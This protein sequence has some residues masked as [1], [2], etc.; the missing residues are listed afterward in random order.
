M[1]LTLHCFG[2]ATPTGEALRHLCP[3]DAFGYSRHP[4]ASS[5]W[6]YPADLNDPSSFHSASI[7]ATP[8]IWISFAP[9]WLFASFLDHL[10][11]HHPERLQGLR[12]VVAC[13]SSSVITKRFAANLSDRQLVAKLYSSER[14]LLTTCKRLSVPCRILSP[15]LIYGKVGSFSD[16]NLS[17][18]LSFMRRTPL[19]L[20][21]SHSGLRQPI[22]ATQLAAVALHLAKQLVDSSFDHKLPERIVIGGDTSLTYADMVFAL[23]EAQPMEDPAR[24]CRL[25]PIPNRLFFAFASPLLLYSP[26]A[27]EAVLRMGANLSDFTPVHQILGSEPQSFPVF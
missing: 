10:A 11:I 7:P 21:P 23:K 15:A 6:L 26:K 9:I 25:L 24:R 3:S 14:N 12:C 16:R 27:F 20:L 17:R 4:S 5:G 1:V 18:L 2:A 13:S 8:A 22:H 19:L